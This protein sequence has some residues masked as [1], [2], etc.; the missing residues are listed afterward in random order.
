[1]ETEPNPSPLSRRTQTGLSQD[2]ILPT[3]PIDRG[4]DLKERA[5]PEPGQFLAALRRRAL[6]ILGVTAAATSVA[7]LLTVSRTPTYNSKFQLLIAPLATEAQDPAAN[8]QENAPA[9]VSPRVDY[10]AQS[11]VLL[12]P[13]LID[14]VV[15]KLQAEYPN[16]TYDSL[17]QDLKIGLP[18]DAG[19]GKILE[20]RYQDPAPQKVKQVLNALIP[21][22]LQYGSQQRQSTA[23]QGLEFVNQQIPPLQARVAA[24]EKQ[25]QTFRQ[26]YG[27]IDPDAQ[28]KQLT[29]QIAAIQKQRQQTQL[30]LNEAQTRYTGLQRQTNLKPEEAIAGSVLSQAPDYQKLLER[31][32]EV[33]S[34]LALE[35][36]Q[37]TDEHP[38]ILYLR[39]QRQKLLPLIQQEAQRAVGKKLAST[40]ASGVSAYQN[41]VRLGL[42]EQLVEAANQIPVFQTQLQALSQTE[43]QLV[44]QAKQF[45]VV[46]RRDGELQRQLATATNQ[47]NQ[48]LDKRETLQFE[49]ATQKQKMPW[50]LIL[51]PSEPD[52]TL[53]SLE[54]NLALGALL[55]LLLG[56]GIALLLERLNTVLYTSRDIKVVT[57]LPIL[58]T[59][60]FQKQLKQLAPAAKMIDLASQSQS[61]ALNNAG[62]AQD[63]VA[64]PFSDAFRS[65][66]KNI[67]FLRFDNPV[68]SVVISS[69]VP[70]EGKSTVA[71]N[72]AQAAAAMGQRVLLVDADLR[73]P[74]VHKLV[75]VA[76]AQGLSE[77]VDHD[78]SL[79]AAIK[80]A[81]FDPNLYV[82]T[83]G[84]IPPDPTSLLSSQKMAHLV[85]VLPKAFNLI[86]YDAPPLGLA[87]ASLLAPQT[88]GLIMVTRLGKIERGVLEQAIE[89]LEVPQAPVLGLVV[90]GV[91]EFSRSE[92]QLYH[93]YYQ[94]PRALR[95]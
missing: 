7:Y 54:R 61:L 91:K 31:L 88:D 1:M 69:A 56:V 32:R 18:Q 75:G 77:V 34:Q 37:Y 10:Q 25:L 39:D 86:I 6:I 70:G 9:T 50:E 71:M 3:I 17:R 51:P 5:K 59:I 68:R 38:R 43:A 12:S 89:T 78:L 83:T 4:P 30:Q 35:S 84:A 57:R 93:S 80:S 15:N 87:D 76:N 63:Y 8:A 2:Q 81:P 28:G 22:Y 33:E 16:L 73:R 14:P 26:Q 79:K 46:A 66:F 42:T 52:A 74:Q 82:L 47:L 55:G 24:L 29:D 72:L 19:E 60:P 20:V 21:V 94:Q 36:A 13:K 65:L 85:A 67:R 53:P 11:K 62:G 27:L 48:L 90:N 45:P 23:R 58:G 49:T 92:K 44:Q 41:S 40:A 64:T 95:G